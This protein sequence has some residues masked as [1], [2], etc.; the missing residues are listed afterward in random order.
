MEFSSLEA[1]IIVTVGLSQPDGE[2]VDLTTKGMLHGRNYSQVNAVCRP[3]PLHGSESVSLTLIPGFTVHT[4]SGG[5]LGEE[6][7][8]HKTEPRA[9]V[10]ARV[11]PPKPDGTLGGEVK[12]CPKGLCIIGLHAPD[13]AIAR[14][15]AGKIR[16]ACGDDVTPM[17]TVAAGDFGAGDGSSTPHAPS[18]KLDTYLNNQFEQLGV[19]KLVSTQGWAGA[20]I[21]TTVTQT[22]RGMNI[23]PISN[24]LRQFGN[25]TDQGPAAIIDMLLPCAYPNAFDGCKK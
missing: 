9:F 24:P 22:G 20:R 17:C 10:A 19:G 23:G 16:H 13:G 7:P 3:G 5:C 14:N 6:T 4:S 2:P 8:G 21:A 15:A 12:G 11:T 25:I 18:S 1:A